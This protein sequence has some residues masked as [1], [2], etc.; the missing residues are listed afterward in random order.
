[1]KR[2]SSHATALALFG[3]LTA[4]SSSSTVAPA[5][6]PSPAAQPAETAADRGP[7]PLGAPA[8]APAVSDADWAGHG[9]DLGEQRYSTLAQISTDNVERLGVAWTYDIPRRGARL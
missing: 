7:V 9:R 4:C 2:L 5:M 3:S 6:A 1:M 8:N